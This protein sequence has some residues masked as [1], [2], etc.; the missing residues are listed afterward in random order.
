MGSPRG[1][2]IGDIER[3]IQER[4]GKKDPNLKIGGLEKKYVTTFKGFK[5]FIVDAEWIRNNLDVIF[6]SGGH[7]RVHTFIPKDEIWIAKGYND[8][9][10]ARC[11]IHEA[12]E[13]GKMSKV[14]YYQAHKTAQ[15]EEFLHPDEESALVKALTRVKHGISDLKKESS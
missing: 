15:K 4:A 12:V 1:P 2:H 11:I 5:V 10:Q 9:Y 7:G 13:Y 3:E 14:P 8:S 6:G